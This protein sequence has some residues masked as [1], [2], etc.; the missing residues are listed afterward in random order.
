MSQPTDPQVLEVV[1]RYRT[2]EFATLTRS[3]VPIAW[4]TAALLRDD[5]TFLVTTSIALPQKA[6]NIRRD[7]RVAMLFSEPTASGLVGAPQVL[8]QGRAGCPD[9]IVTDVSGDVEYW[10]RLHE[11]QPFNALYSRNAL[12]RRF[13]DWYYMRLHITVTPT[14]WTTRPPLPAGRPPAAGSPDGLA[15]RAL[16]QLAGYPSAVLATRT[17]DGMP[18]LRRVHVTGPGAAGR[19]RLDVPPDEQLREGPA[20]L[21]AH[22]HDEQLW[23]LRS[24]VVTG[25]LI[26]ADVWTFRPE[27]IVGAGDASPVGMLRELGRLRRTAKGYLEKRSLPRPS[28]AWSSVRALGDDVRAG[29]TGRRPEPGAVRP[30]SR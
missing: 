8:V 30:S 29:G 18:S 5:G 27:R 11:R 16:A 3:G 15:G 9:E 10:R 6:Y 13:F 17:D 20:S 25:E 26:P 21:L 7:D 19:L 24:V 14:S 2:C 22:G 4:P 1:D 12:T 23:S 28:I